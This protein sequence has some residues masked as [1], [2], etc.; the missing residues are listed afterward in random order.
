MYASRS[1]VSA[2]AR[3]QAALA[4]RGEGGQRPACAQRRLAPAAHELQRLHDEFDFA[5]AARTELDV[6]GMVA[7]PA[8]LANLPMHVAQP[9]VG[10]EIEVLAVDEGR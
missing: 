8:L 10:V 4:Q 6:V 5:N 7:Y 2:G 1:S 3:Q 9:V